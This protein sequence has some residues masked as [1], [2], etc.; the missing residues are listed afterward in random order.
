MLCYNERVMNQLSVYQL[1]IQGLLTQNHWAVSWL[2]QSKKYQELL[3][4]LVN[5]KTSP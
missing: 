3:G 2:G 4:T 5:S 1:P